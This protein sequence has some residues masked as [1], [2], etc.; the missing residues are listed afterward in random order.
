MSDRPTVA[1]FSVSAGAGHVRA[2]EALEATAA[3]RFPHA[4][5]VHVDLMDLVPRLF[6]TVYADSYTPIVARH[7]ALWGYL[8]AETDRRKIDSALD[9]LRTAVERVNTQKLKVLLRE[10]NPAAVICTHFLPAELFSRWRR[11]GHWRKPVWAVITDHDVHMLWIH[12]H[13]TGY[14]VASE[15][16]AWRLK[17]RGVGEARIEVTGIPIMPAF[18]SMPD[19]AACAREIGVDPAKITLLLMSGGAGVIPLNKLAR[20]ILELRNDVQVIGLAGRNRRLLEALGDVARDFPGRLVPV[21]FTSTVDRLMAASDLAVTKSGG[22]TTSECLA[23]GLPMLVVMPT[24][25][26]EERNADYLLE[27][28]VALKAYDEAG[29]AYKLRLLLEEPGRLQAM[30]TRARQLGRPDAAASI[31]RLVLEPSGL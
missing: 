9:K 8:Y 30:R 21:P 22:L 1:V 27:H 2:A 6:K 25:G 11:K 15:E 29:L 4:R 7:P 20:R 16:V 24:P 14:C 10:L 26:Q 23:Q 3:T 18:G 28:G 12:R 13:L 5:V 31:L 19:R 17:G